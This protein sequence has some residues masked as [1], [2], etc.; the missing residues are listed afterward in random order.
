MRLLAED[1][2]VVATGEQTSSRIR[3][4]RL[5]HMQVRDVA[6]LTG[7]AVEVGSF[8]SPRTKKEVSALPIS[9]I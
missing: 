3:S 8:V 5:G 7:R 9:P 1:S 2:L 6:T 4:D